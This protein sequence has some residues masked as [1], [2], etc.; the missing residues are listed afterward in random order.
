MKCTLLLPTEPLSIN[1]QHC[2]DKRYTTSAWKDW[3]AN[4]LIMLSKPNNQNSIQKLKKAFNP[5]DHYIKVQMISYYPRDQFWTESNQLSSKTH[6]VT[7]IEKPLV[8]VLFLPK[9]HGTGT[10]MKGPNFNIDDKY[11]KEFNSRQRVGDYHLIELHIELK[12]LHE[13]DNN[14]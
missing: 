14:L 12:S 3:A 9:F 6:D 1:K 11:I 10:V 2:R 7:N 5:K 8:D 13:L 4:V